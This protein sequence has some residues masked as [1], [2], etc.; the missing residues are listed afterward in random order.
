MKGQLPLAWAVLFAVSV[1][2]LS[3][4]ICR[5]EASPAEAPDPAREAEALYAAGRY[6]EA[7]P[8]LRQLDE[9]G[10]AT[11]TT[12]YRLAYCQRITGDEAGAAETERRARESLEGELAGSQS[13]EVP[14]YLANAYRNSGRDADAKRIAAE[15]T[16]RVERGDLPR[17]ET[18]T[19]MFQLAKLYADQELGQQASQWYAQAADN[20]TER[21]RP[22]GHYVRWASRYVAERAFRQQDYGTAERYFTLLF[23]AGEGRAVDFNRLAVSSARLG[24]YEAAAEAWHRAELAGPADANPARYARQ[25]A[26]MASRLEPVPEKAPSGRAW[27]E[28]TQEELEALM[29]EQSDRVKAIRAE[30]AEAGEIDKPTLREYRQRMKAVRAVFVPAALEYALRGH[31]I[32]QTAFFG[33]Y[34]PLIFSRKAWKL[35]SKT[36][37]KDAAP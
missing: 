14:F 27:T 4:G 11:G 10:E 21:G 25:L 36:R 6:A 22:G 23:E 30:V 9:D 2:A 1:S 16:A 5:A 35:E 8:L 12:L 31:D 7:L 19:G 24:K 17:P 37:Q 3:Y 13:V 34:A 18:G 29:M 26:T 20:L 28:L 33:G 32:R 15:T